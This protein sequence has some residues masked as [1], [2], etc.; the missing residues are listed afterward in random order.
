MQLALP[1]KVI[2]AEVEEVGGG[3]VLLNRVNFDDLVAHCTFRRKMAPLKWDMGNYVKQCKNIGNY[4][5]RNYGLL[6]LKT[7]IELRS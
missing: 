4:A 3:G 7:T 1:E 6:R 5:I 2:A